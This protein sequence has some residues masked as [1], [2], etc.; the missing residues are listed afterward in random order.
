MPQLNTQIVAYT[1]LIVCEKIAS[2][3]QVLK[4]THT[5][6]IGSFFLP[7]SVVTNYYFI[8]IGLFRPLIQLN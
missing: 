6:K 1:F 3:C 5:K 4:E 8:K 7:D 2:F